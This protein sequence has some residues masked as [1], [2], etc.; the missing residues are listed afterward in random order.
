MSATAEQTLGEVTPHLAAADIAAGHAR[1][2]WLT[3]A[4]SPKRGGK[5]LP[6][7]DLEW[8]I[9]LFL[10][11][12]GFGKT[13]SLVQWMWWDLWRVPGIIGHW[14]GPTVGDATGTGFEGPAGFQAIV[15]AECLWRASWDRA[16]RGGNRPLLKFSNGSFIRGFGATDEGARLRGPQCH[17]LAGD[18]LRE[19][20]KPKGALEKTLNNALFGLRLPYPD[21]T[22]ARALL[23]TTPKVI[24]F[25]KRLEKRQGV[26]VVRG[27]TYENMD[28]L[29]PALRNHLMAMAGTLLGKQEIDGLYIDEES[30]LS[31]IKRAWV[32]LWPAG[33][34]LPEFSFV[35]ESYDTAGTDDDYDPETQEN[36]PTACTVWGVFNINLA[37]TLPE[38]KAMGL[39]SKYG[40]LLC[41]AW[42]EWLPFPD[43]L[44]RARKQHRTKWGKNGHKSDLVLIE[45]KSSGPQMRS[46]LAKW[47]VPCWP[48]NPGSAGKTQRLHAAAPFWKQGCVFVPES[49]RED[50]SGM[51]RDWVEGMLE[52][53]CAYAGEGSVEHD[54]YVDSTSQAI[55]YL[56]QRGFLEATPDVPFIDVEEKRE[57]DEDDARVIWQR[58]KAKQGPRNPYMA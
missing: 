3:Q 15:P 1:H 19:W 17:A 44:E 48:S 41:E 47:G 6:P 16:Y 5:Q 30:D 45:D 14:V 22:P 50:R 12:R 25:L 56:A 58:E 55:S 42:E 40:V 54:D 27:T 18:E 2:R 34:K 43:L 49:N 57:K 37:F 28:N 29:N 11:G 10:A 39:R 38:R 51:P 31:I 8:Q 4:R 35:L 33:R 13:L 20:D 9:L 53:V 26:R 52:Q 21:G 36:D 7:P 24:P 46:M 32:K 23:G